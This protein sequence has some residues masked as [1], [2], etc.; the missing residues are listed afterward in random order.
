MESVLLTPLFLSGLAIYIGVF[1]ATR[2]M[3]QYIE[4]R[5]YL[6]TGECLRY[7]HA[8]HQVMLLSIVGVVAM[9]ISVLVLVRLSFQHV[10]RLTLGDN[11]FSLLGL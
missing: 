10:F 8:M 3:R 7:R 1:C 9:V 6:L 4:S 2:A 5:T 11:V